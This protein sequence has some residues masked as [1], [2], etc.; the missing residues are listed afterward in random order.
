[1]KFGFFSLNDFDLEEY[2]KYEQLKNGDM[3]WIVPRKFIAFL[4]PSTEF[5]NYTHYPEKYINYFLANDVSAVIRL[6][7]KSYDAHR[8]RRK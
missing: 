3:N 2:E 4:G 8:Y 7:R 5:E 1:M 6:N